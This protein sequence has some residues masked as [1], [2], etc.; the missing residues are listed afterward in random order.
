[1]SRPCENSVVHK[2]GRLNTSRNCL[3]LLPACS[4]RVWFLQGHHQ[5]HH[6][7]SRLSLLQAWAFLHGTEQPSDTTA[8]LVPFT[9]FLPIALHVSIRVPPLEPQ[10]AKYRNLPRIPNR[11][12]CLA[13]LSQLAPNTYH[14][15]QTA[16]TTGHAESTAAAAA[17]AAAAAAPGGPAP[18]WP[19]PDERPTSA[20]HEL[21]LPRRPPGA[22]VASTATH[23]CDVG[24]QPAAN[25]LCAASSRREDDVRRSAQEGNQKEDENGVLDLSQA[26]NKGTRQWTPLLQWM[27]ASPVCLFGGAAEGACS[28]FHC[29]RLTS[30]FKRK[31]ST[32][33]LHDMSTYQR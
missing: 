13:S 10:W 19:A 6:H 14:R 25:A 7:P 22:I 32:L 5:G 21:L 8:G 3:V 26:T 4:G 33:S 30:R 12:Q 15:R 23:E 16:V 18:D 11:L 31:I 2:K 29:D 17:P 9:A 27:T 20:A 1:M 24:S 28:R